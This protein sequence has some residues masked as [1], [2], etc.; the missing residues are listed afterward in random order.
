MF[1]RC[2]QVQEDGLFDP[3]RAAADQATDRGMG[4]TKSTRARLLDL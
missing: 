1:K 2:L 4:T 3:E